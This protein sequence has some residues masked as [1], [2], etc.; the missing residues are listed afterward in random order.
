MSCMNINHLLICRYH[1]ACGYASDWD[2]YIL[3]FEPW[4]SKINKITN[5]PAKGSDQAAQLRILISSRCPHEAKHTIC[6]TLAASGAP[7]EDSNPNMRMR[8]LICL[9]CLFKHT[10]DCVCCVNTAYILTQKRNFLF[11]MNFICFK[12]NIQNMVLICISL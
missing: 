4:H 2:I 11:F 6:C 3:L 5:V 9:F 8:R 1:C 12:T 7:K 10:T